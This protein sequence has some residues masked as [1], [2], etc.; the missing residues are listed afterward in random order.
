MRCSNL[1]FMFV[2]AAMALVPGLVNAQNSP[3][4]AADESP[5][6][7]HFRAYLEDDWKRWMVE[8]PQ[9]A[10]VVGFPGQNRRWSDDSPQGIEERKQHLH[11]SLTKLKSFS[12]DTLPLAEQLDYDLYLELLSTSEEGLQYGD[13]PLPFRN[14]VPGNIWMPM[15]QMGGV[16]QYAAAVI[17]TMPNRTVAD[18]EDI[19][20]RLA[21]LPVVV[22]QEQ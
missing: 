6:A 15:T 13:D 1:L 16:Q 9:M 18:Y 8:Y 12:R 5:A 14:V 22:Q 10:T 11:E 3:G 21:A 19:L 20:A 2:S 7:R 17:S 4:R